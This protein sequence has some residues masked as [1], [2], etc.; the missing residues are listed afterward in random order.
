MNPASSLYIS[1]QPRRFDLSAQS[2][3]PPRLSAVPPV[4]SAY[5][6]RNAVI[7]RGLRQRH[8]QPGSW[9]ATRFVGVHRLVDKVVGRNRITLHF[10][11]ISDRKPNA[12]TIERA[13]LWISSFM[14]GLF[15]KPCGGLSPRPGINLSEQRRT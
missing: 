5:S 15:P 13:G 7:C 2:V 9:I 6:S 10:N 11:G 14:R 12:V 3:L 4:T 8:F 1:R